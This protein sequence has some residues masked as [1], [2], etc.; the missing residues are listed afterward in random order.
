MI[1]ICNL[2]KTYLLI[3]TVSIFNDLNLFIFFLK[4]IPFPLAQE[5]TV[6]RICI[7]FIINKKLAFNSNAFF[8]LVLGFKIYFYAADH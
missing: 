2:I 5:V 7:I 1:K 3:G 6:L 4:N 8:E